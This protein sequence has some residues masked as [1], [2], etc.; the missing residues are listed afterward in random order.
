MSGV[1]TMEYSERTAAF[2]GELRERF[3]AAG[4]IGTSG[5]NKE[6]ARNMDLWNNAA[7]RK[8]GKKSKTREELF[9]H[10]LQALK[11]GALITDLND[12]RRYSANAEAI[13]L[14]ITERV[15]VL[16]ESDT[17]ENLLFLDTHK[18]L[19]FS[20]EEF[21]AKIKSGEYGDY[22]IRK[23]RG[24][25]IPASKRDGSNNLAVRSSF[26]PF[27][28][29]SNQLQALPQSADRSSRARQAF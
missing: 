27:S 1:Y 11:N 8:Y 19:A 17:G 14:K 6:K 10:L 2:L 12:K 20:R 5:P 15:I 7:G 22:E 23:I 3:P 13:D 4:S 25:E 29:F 9:Q 18:M 28:P 21:V 26:W 16:K 24:K